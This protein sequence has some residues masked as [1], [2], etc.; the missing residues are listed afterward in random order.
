MEAVIVC[1]IS[2]GTGGLV[3]GSNGSGDRYVCE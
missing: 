2:S 3:D 1:G